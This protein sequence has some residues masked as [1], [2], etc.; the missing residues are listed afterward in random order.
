MR[1]SA[2]K[3]K[4]GLVAHALRSTTRDAFGPCPWWYYAL[5]KAYPALSGDWFRYI[6]SL[7]RHADQL[8]KCSA[9]GDV[10]GKTRP[11]VLT[12]VDAS[13]DRTARKLYSMSSVCH[14]DR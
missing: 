14:P 1:I 13:P 9:L 5:D 8:R 6:G 12:A 10:Q 3:P 2:H 7:H 11:Y 4:L